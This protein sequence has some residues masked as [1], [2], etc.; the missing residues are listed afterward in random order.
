MNGVKKVSGQ[1]SVGRKFFW[2]RVNETLGCPTKSQ[3]F[4]NHTFLISFSYFFAAVNMILKAWFAWLLS[5]MILW[6]QAFST[7]VK[8]EMRTQDPPVA[9]SET[10]PTTLGI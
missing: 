2:C 7:E 1:K 9:S 8:K 3:G 10:P 6:T 5:A 4:V